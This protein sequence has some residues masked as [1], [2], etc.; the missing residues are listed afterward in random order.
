MGSQITGRMTYN[1]MLLRF[2]VLILM[3]LLCDG[4]RYF[5]VCY[6]V[7]PNEEFMCGYFNVNQKACRLP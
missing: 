1:E 3:S 6:V 4:H 5:M 7:M 2:F